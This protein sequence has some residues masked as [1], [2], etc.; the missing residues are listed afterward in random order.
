MSGNLN[1]FFQIYDIA[2]ELVGLPNGKH[3][4]ATK[5]GRVK[6]GAD[7]F[8]DNVLYVPAL[9]CNLMFLEI[10]VAH[11]FLTIV[12]DYS[13]CTWV[14]LMLGKYEVSQLIKG[15]YQ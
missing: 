7:L 12:D 1:L 11:Y 8:L 2:S 4:T 9:T 15:N 3:I 5:E 14:Y 6:I 13:R 10:F